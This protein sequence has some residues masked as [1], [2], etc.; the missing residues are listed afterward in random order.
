MT[1][2]EHER[3]HGKAVMDCD[4]A[5]C[6]LLFEREREAYDRRMSVAGAKAPCNASAIA[7]IM[8][9]ADAIAWDARSIIGTSEAKGA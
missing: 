6:R 8:R 7:G 5:E 2:L 9:R 4:I 1:R 3:A